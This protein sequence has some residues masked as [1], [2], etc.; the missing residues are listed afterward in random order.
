[1]VSELDEVI[2]E[3][4]CLL[5]PYGFD[6]DQD[7]PVVTEAKLRQLTLVILL[8]AL[9]VQ[10]AWEHLGDLLRATRSTRGGIGVESYS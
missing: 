3:L 9:E 2:A 10:D 8:A 1:M 6:S 7:V 5:V 4:R